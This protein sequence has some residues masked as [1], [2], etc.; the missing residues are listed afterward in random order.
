MLYSLPGPETSRKGHQ[1]LCGTHEP[2][3]TRAVGSLLSLRYNRVSRLAPPCREFLRI[4][5]NFQRHKVGIQVPRLR[6]DS[7]RSGHLEIHPRPAVV[8]VPDCPTEPTPL[9]SCAN[10]HLGG[11]GRNEGPNEQEGRFCA[12]HRNPESCIRTS[13]RICCEARER[14]SVGYWWDLASSR[15]NASNVW[16]YVPP[17]PS[18]FIARPFPF[19]VDMGISGR[20]HQTTSDH[21]SH[22]FVS[23]LDQSAAIKTLLEL[24]AAPYPAL[25]TPP[26][27]PLDSSHVAR[28]YKTLLQGGHFDRSS[29]S[30]TKPSSSFSP[31][32]FASAF[33]ITVG[34][35]VTVAMA[36]GSGAFVVAELCNRV[37]AGG[38]GVERGLLRTWF[39]DDGFS[40]SILDKG[41]K[42]S[43]ILLES[44]KNLLPT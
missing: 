6:V 1:T 20:L 26:S 37:G 31:S 11:N 32:E 25:P 19:H 40:E 15:D 24:I 38:T 3:R 35:P 23:F 8:A 28:A 39:A 13:A 7:R 5:A 42:G 29:K 34:Q 36:R 21:L 4:D 17:G 18:L 41:P 44:I 22:S 33:I 10:C 12:S 9:Y 30:V 27:H 2:R 16:R 14:G 43:T